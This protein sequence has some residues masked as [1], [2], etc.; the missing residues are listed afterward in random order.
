MQH[1]ITNYI[2][3]VGIHFLIF[4]IF[5]LIFSFF[6]FIKGFPTNET[7]SQWD[8]GWYKSIIKDGYSFI[9]NK[10]S[11]V[12]FFPLF[13][14]FWK[15][16]HLSPIGISIVNLLCFYSGMFILFKTFNLD[17]KKL[18]LLLSIPS[19]FFCYVPYTESLF[20]L[21]GSFIIYGLKRNHWL[22]ILGVFLAC[23]TRSASLIFIPIILFS[24][25]YNL[26]TER[27]NNRKI[28][29]ETVLLILTAIIATL[30]AQYIQYLYT[31][32]FFTIFKAQKAW[33]R[34]IKIPTLYFTTWDEARL[35]WLDGLAF[36]IGTLGIVLSVILLIKKIKNKHKKIS[37]DYLFSISYLGLVTLVTVLYSGEDANGGTSLVSLNRYVF[38]TPFFMLFLIMLLKR[39]R[40]MK[41][42][43]IVFITIS[44]ITWLMFHATGYLHNLDCFVVSSAKTQI[45]FGIIILYSLIY[46][47]LSN[48]KYLSLLWSGFYLLNIIIQIFLF[49]SFLNGI[50]IG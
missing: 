11:N 20:F 47:L 6:G 44:I 1:R 40:L 10:Q 29:K 32:Q 9:E 33:N 16:T 48:K 13:P 41:N 45:Y 34:I 46:M 2:K 22:V 50:W 27:E 25:L 39:N 12:A 3:L 36:L 17:A 42:Q 5:Y 15:F 21:A 8:V 19:L 49:N 14:L 23:L 4:C 18:L 7:I 30:L 35:I 38:S 26:T 31:G 43:L 37:S 28:I 24:K